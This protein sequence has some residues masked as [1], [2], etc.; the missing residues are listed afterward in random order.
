MV[1]IGAHN[2]SAHSNS[3]VIAMQKTTTDQ[4]RCTWSLVCSPNKTVIL[5]ALNTGVPIVKFLG[6]AE[7]ML[8]PDTL[9]NIARVRNC[10]EITI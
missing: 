5:G 2:I 3:I 9:N 10:S 1:C 8:K 7:T 4:V 6:K